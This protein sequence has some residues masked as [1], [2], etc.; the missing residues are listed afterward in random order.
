MEG[1]HRQNKEVMQEKEEMECESKEIGK[2]TK[3][4]QDGSSD[5]LYNLGRDWE[6][7]SP[8]KLRRPW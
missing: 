8:S 1:A 3:A 4:D 7:I 2:K 6:L 5:P